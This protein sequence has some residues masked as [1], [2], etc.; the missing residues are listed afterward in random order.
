MVDVAAGSVSAAQEGE[1]EGDREQRGRQH[2]DNSSGFRGRE[3]HF[4]DASRFHC[5][6]H[7]YY[8]HSGLLFNVGFNP[9]DV[10][11][12]ESRRVETQ[13]A[14][15]AIEENTR[16]LYYYNRCYTLVFDD[17]VCSSE[18]KEWFE[19]AS[20]E[21]ILTSKSPLWRDEKLYFTLPHG[22][23]TGRDI[24]ESAPVS[25][26]ANEMP[27]VNHLL[28]KH[29]GFIKLNSSPTDLLVRRRQR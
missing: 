14:F 22:Y 12:L 24:K 4:P 11:A 26:F 9:F 23:S 8:R 28:L 18:R 1:E 6:R 10:I 2:T 16:F 25:K 7:R 29:M 5:N 17:Y 15:K 19:R 20:R 21:R 27:L 3:L 13:S